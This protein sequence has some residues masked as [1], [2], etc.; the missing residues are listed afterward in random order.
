[1]PMSND[2]LIEARAGER[3][4]T[5]EQLHQDNPHREQIGACISLRS[6]SELLGGRIGGGAKDRSDP[7]ALNIEVLDQTKV[8]DPR[9]KPAE[10]NIAEDVAWF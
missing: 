10:L 8:C 7:G 1:M 3:A 4:V 6:I 2:Q 9:S 5:A